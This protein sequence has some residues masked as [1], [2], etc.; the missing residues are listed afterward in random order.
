MKQVYDF[1]NE[2]KAY[3]NKK[4]LARYPLRPNDYDTFPEF[5]YAEEPFTAPIARLVPS[6]LG[7]LVL[8][9]GVILVPF[10]ALRN[11]QIAAR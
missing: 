8:F 6:L 1:H 7:M 4:F 9:L 5:K 11:Y 3:F 10:V 2:W